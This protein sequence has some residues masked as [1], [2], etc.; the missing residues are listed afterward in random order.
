MYGCLEDHWL[1]EQTQNDETKSNF[2][3][4]GDKWETN[5][6]FAFCL[7]LPKLDYHS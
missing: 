2:M 1:T 7:A 4:D 3:F 6:N 5:G